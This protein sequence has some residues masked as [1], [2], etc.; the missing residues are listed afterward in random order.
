[1]I[2]RTLK[3]IFCVQLK[4]L[5]NQQFWR[6]K[7][8]FKKPYKNVFEYYYKFLQRFFQKIYMV[9]LYYIFKKNSYGIL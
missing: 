5:F 4:F 6:K 8:F 9:F 3:R 1:M 7:L 2:Y